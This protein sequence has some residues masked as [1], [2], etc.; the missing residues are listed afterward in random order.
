MNAIKEFNS[1]HI[2]QLKA[3]M[4]ELVNSGVDDG[5][6]I[7][8]TD[9][10]RFVQ[11]TYSTGEGLTFDLPRMGL[12]EGEVSRVCKVEGLE[13]MNETEMSFLLKIGVDTRMGARLANC[14]FR[15][16]FRCPEDYNVHV[17][18]DLEE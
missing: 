18:I 5:F 4:D 11:F 16:V 2:N 10:G 9:E 17:T 13:A 1:D 14:I 3:A 12:S 7:F 8:E 6:I 15:S